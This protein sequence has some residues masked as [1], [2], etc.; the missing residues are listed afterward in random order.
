MSRGRVNPKVKGEKGAGLFEGVGGGHSMLH[1][2]NVESGAKEVQELDPL[3]RYR[4]FLRG[5]YYLRG[6]EF[7]PM[8]VSWCSLSLIAG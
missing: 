1:G 2:A 7:A 8:L 3:E 4:D 6:L 5:F